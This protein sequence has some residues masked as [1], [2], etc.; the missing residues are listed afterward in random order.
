MSGFNFIS[1]VDWVMRKTEKYKIEKQAS[2]GSLP[3]SLKILI[4]PMIWPSCPV[5]TKI[6]KKK[7]QKDFP[8]MQN[9]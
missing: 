8:N 2:T 9:I 7:E 4:I 5:G 1:A 6:S 3:P